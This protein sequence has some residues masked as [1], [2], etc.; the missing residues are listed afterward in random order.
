MTQIKISARLKAL[1]TAKGFADKQLVLVTDDGG[2]K[3]SL[4]GGACSIGTKFTLIVLD[5]SDP[6]YDVAVDNNQQLALWTSAYDLIFFNDGIQMD[7]DQGRISIKDNAHMLDNAVQIA[8][9]AEVLAAFEQ[10]VPADNLT[11]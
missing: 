3:Y 5:Q 9:G 4:H 10:G 6:E 8:K 2:G 1:L 11:C 7:Y